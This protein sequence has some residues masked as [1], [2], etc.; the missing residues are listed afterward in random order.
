MKSIRWQWY[1]FND[2]EIYLI[3]IGSIHWTLS[4]TCFILPR[5]PPDIPKQWVYGIFFSFSSKPSI[6]PTK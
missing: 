5:A 3:A 1:L 2:H 6:R 4:A